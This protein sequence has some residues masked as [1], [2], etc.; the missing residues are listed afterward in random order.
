MWQRSLDI[1]PDTKG[2]IQLKKYLKY[3]KKV[4]YKDGVTQPYGNKC[5]LYVFTNNTTA[6]AIQVIANCR[7]MFKDP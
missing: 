1:D 5:K 2:S 4:T 3:N 6:D 7:I